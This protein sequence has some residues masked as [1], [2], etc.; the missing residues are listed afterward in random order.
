MGLKN[1]SDVCKL[2]MLTQEI[3]AI[4]EILF[5]CG[6]IDDGVKKNY[7]AAA[8]EFVVK[9]N[10]PPPPITLVESYVDWMLECGY[11][12]SEIRVRAAILATFED[13]RAHAVRRMKEEHYPAIPLDVHSAFFNDWSSWVDS[14]PYNRVVEHLNSSHPNNTL[15]IVE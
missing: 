3:R 13:M 1:A 11:D 15:W 2:P 4:S 14:D 6:K 9:E 12:E 5:A 7:L 10:P 8:L